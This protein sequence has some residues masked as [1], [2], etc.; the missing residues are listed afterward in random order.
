MK[1]HH[2]GARVTL[3]ETYWSLYDL[4]KQKNWIEAAQKHCAKAIELVN[5]GAESHTCLGTIENGTGKYEKGVERFLQATQLDPTNDQAYWHLA[6]AYQNLNQLEKAEETLKRSISVRPY[7]GM[8]RS[9]V[10]AGDTAKARKS[11]KDFFELWKDADLDVP[12]LK[13]ANA[14]YA[15][16]Q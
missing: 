9:L 10:F 3:G 16:L 13:Q 15:R 12:V 6:E 5:A 11:Y 7:L 8:A 1:S 14:E 4:T 2:I